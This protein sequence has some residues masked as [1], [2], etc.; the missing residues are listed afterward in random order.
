V[1]DAA[2]ILAT[3]ERVLVVDWPSRDVPDALFAAGYDV[4]VLGGPGPDDYS[5]RRPETVDLVYCYRPLEGLPWVVE[6]AR[7]LG[8]KAVWHQSGR[9]SDDGTD[10]TACWLPEEAAREARAVVKAAGLLSVHDV[11]IA[12]AVRRL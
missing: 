11:Y 7:D 12:D 10:P 4:Y 1:S 9:T 5:P 6:K 2:E 8:A 3:A